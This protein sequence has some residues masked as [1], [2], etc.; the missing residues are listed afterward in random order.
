MKWY[1]SWL[2]FNCSKC[3]KKVVPGCKVALDDGGKVYCYR[4]GD[5][6]A[7]SA[8]HRF[9]ARAAYG[10]INHMRDI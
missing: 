8:D 9:I 5:N 6:I 1:K 3:G 7:R 2:A 10:V 4:C